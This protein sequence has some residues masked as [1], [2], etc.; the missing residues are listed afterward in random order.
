MDGMGTLISNFPGRILGDLQVMKHLNSAV[1]SWKLC[2]LFAWQ[3]GSVRW[4]KEL[5]ETQVWRKNRGVCGCCFFC[6]W[7]FGFW[8]AD[9][10]FFP[11][12]EI[13]AD[14]EVLFFFSL[15]GGVFFALK[16]MFDS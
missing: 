2:G 11:W 16:M 13:S 10:F 4:P 5:E 9:C 14:V 1:G 8:F 15:V 3:G 7:C 12:G 6:L